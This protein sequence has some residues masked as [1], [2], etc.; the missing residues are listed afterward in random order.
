MR[1]QPILRASTEQLLR[2]YGRAFAPNRGELSLGATE[3]DKSLAIKL[4]FSAERVVGY[5]LHFAHGGNASARAAG[6]GL[7]RAVL[8]TVTA[9]LRW[10][11]AAP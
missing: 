3:W 2:A 8:G 4:R 7:L 6:A 11:C 5:E 9:I 1:E 10:H